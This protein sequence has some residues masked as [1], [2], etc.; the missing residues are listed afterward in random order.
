MPPRLSKQLGVTPEP[1]TQELARFDPG[2]PP[3]GRDGDGG[4]AASRLKTPAIR[5][6]ALPTR[7]S[8]A[9]LPFTSVGADEE[10]AYFA[11]GVADDIITE[12]SRNRDLFVVARHSSF[13]IA[14][15]ESDPAAIGRALGVR[16]LLGG[17]VRRARERLRL[18]L[19]PRRVRVGQGGVGRALRPQDRGPVRRPARGRH[20]P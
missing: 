17:S 7:P 6:A 12:L 15:R 13:F 1:E 16:H 9:V 3:R 10:G 19:A 8:I 20:G 18:T 2:E 14:Q 11:E 4:G 5:S